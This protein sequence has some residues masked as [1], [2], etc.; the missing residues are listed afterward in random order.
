[1]NMKTVYDSYYNYIRFPYALQD[2]DSMQ[3]FLLEHNWICTDSYWCTRNNLNL[4]CEKYKSFS[5]IRKKLWVDPNFLVN[6]GFPPRND[7]FK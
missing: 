1:M 4:A 3:K 5:E 6:F 2:D 7:W